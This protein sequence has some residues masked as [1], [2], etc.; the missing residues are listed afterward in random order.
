MFEI[1]LMVSDGKDHGM[2][3]TSQTN[4]SPGGR[5]NLVSEVTAGLRGRIESGEFEVG[6]RLPSEAQLTEAFSVSRTVIREAIAAY[7]A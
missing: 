1:Q 3:K 6:D 2:T 4:I 5:R 7:A